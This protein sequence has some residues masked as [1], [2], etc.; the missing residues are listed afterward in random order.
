[1]QPAHNPGK[2]N[3][4]VLRIGN[5]QIR[6]FKYSLMAVKCGEGFLA[7]CHPNNES[8]TDR[9]QVVS[10]VRLIQF[11][12][13]EIR[14]VNNIVD[15]SHSC[16]RKSLLYPSW[17]FGN[18]NSRHGHDG[19]PAAALWRLDLNRHRLLGT[20]NAKFGYGLLTHLCQACSKISSHSEITSAVWPIT[21]Y[22]KI[23]NDVRLHAHRLIDINSKWR[24]AWQNK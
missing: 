23:K 12:I 20:E 13:H 15:G 16:P 19:E 14:Y 9:L 17:R 22:I 21:R 5:N 18:D 2:A 8:S 1:M 11:K 24:V 10:V 3:G 6:L 7:F 4:R